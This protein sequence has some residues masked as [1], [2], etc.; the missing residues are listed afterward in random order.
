MQYAFEDFINIKTN[1]IAELTTKY[2]DNILQKAQKL[3]QDEEHLE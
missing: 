1:K 3:N 2:F